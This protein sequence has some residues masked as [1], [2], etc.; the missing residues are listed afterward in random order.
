MVE[1]RTDS[2]GRGDSAG[3]A[4]QGSALIVALWVTG[5]LAM[6]TATL[7]FEA[8]L[9]ARITNYYRN[10]TLAYYSAR[11]GIS[12]AEL[13]INK[14]TGLRG[15]QPDAARADSERWYEDALRL[16]EGGHVTVEHTLPVEKGVAASIRLRIEPEPAR[17]NINVIAQNLDDESI[18]RIL[19]V[20]GVPQE[21]WPTLIDSLYDWVDADDDPRPDGAETED[22][23]AN[24]DPPYRAKNGPLDTV[25]EMLL[26]RGFTREILEGGRLTGGF[27][28]TEEI[29]IRGIGDLLTVHGDG[30]V[31]V[32]AASREVLLT[33]P[34][35]DDLIAGDIVRLR[36]EWIDGAGED[37]R[38]FRSDA[39]VFAEFPDFPEEARSMVTVDS[40]I[41]RIESVGILYGVEHKIW[42]TVQLSQGR[43]QVFEW[44]E[45]D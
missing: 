39:E 1:K 11:S 7:A 10:R 17:R 27:F 20:G 6:L 38:G 16:A 2:C 44:R 18:E 34:G 40:G 19:D 42:C 29:R 4:R 43:L 3:S 26:I 24:L 22:Y 15:S 35:M 28:D 30:R 25:G 31:N 23:Y 12:L 21:L 14:S 41:Y 32:N 45:D 5:L 8:H 33:L 9:E 13:L 37:R 36:S